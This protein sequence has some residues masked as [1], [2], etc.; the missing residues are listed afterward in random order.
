M[1]VLLSLGCVV[2]GGLMWKHIS[3]AHVGHLGHLIQAPDCI[4][5]AK[6]V[7]VHCA[8]YVVVHCAKSAV[9]WRHHSVKNC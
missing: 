5:C 4:H 6:Y 9:S 1:H 2:G 3:P 8:K 7:V